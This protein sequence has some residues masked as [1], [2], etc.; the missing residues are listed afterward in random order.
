MT[1]ALLCPNGHKLLC[2]DEQAGKRGKCPQCQATF[3]VPE[4]KAPG[5][6]GPL[7]GAQS[8]VGGPTAG[9]PIAGGSSP[10]VVSGS[11]A[12][13]MVS[14]SSPKPVPV[15]VA[16]G[17]GP[18][19]PIPKP[20]LPAAPPNPIRATAEGAQVGEGEFAF[21]CPNNHHLAGAVSLGGQPGQCPACGAKF[22]VPSE[23]ELVEV[24]EAPFNPL[25]HGAPNQVAGSTPFGQQRRSM[26]DFFERLW[27]YKG[28]GGAVEVS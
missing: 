18:M 27:A 12:M 15:P 1:I 14:G 5:S 24:E 19:A 8:A 21:L 13:P 4:L 3:R 25:L 22:L 26:T 16:A 7:S 9:G 17:S 6:S 28:R 23:D 20:I 2:P 11:G 10:S